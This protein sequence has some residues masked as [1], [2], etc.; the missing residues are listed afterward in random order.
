MTEQDNKPKTLQDH[1]YSEES[2]DNFH[3][4]QMRFPWLAVA[5]TIV[6]TLCIVAVIM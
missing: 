3:A 4:D 2:I 6:V 5:I 1:P